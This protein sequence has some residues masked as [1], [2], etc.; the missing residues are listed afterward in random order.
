MMHY[1]MAFM[2]TPVLAHWSQS[3]WTYILSPNLSDPVQAV[4]WMMPWPMWRVMMS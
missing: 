1:L 3:Q 4:W 2:C